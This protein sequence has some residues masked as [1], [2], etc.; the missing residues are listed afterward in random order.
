MDIGPWIPFVAK[1]A[2]STCCAPLLDHLAGKK[3]DTW[4]YKIVVKEISRPCPCS[5]ALRPDEMDEKVRKSGENDH[6]SLAPAVIQ[7]AANDVA[8]KLIE[9]PISSVRFVDAEIHLAAWLQYAEIFR[10]RAVRIV[11]VMNHAI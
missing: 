9:Q 6:E 3:R 5:L 11:R 1:N 7:T 4:C 8:W 10:E 2:S